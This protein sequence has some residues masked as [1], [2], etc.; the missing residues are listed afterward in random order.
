MCIK[1]LIED[2]EEVDGVVAEEAS[3]IEWEIC[4]LDVAVAEAEVVA[5]VAEEEA[6]DVED[7]EVAEEAEEEVISYSS[8]RMEIMSIKEFIFYSE[9]F[10]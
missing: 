6:E 9:I 1:C 2:E 5:G 8:L 3:L 10:Y 4:K 7:E